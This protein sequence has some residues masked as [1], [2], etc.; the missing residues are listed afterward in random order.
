MKLKDRSRNLRSNRSLKCLFQ[1]PGLFFSIGYH[2]DPFCGHD[3]LYPHGICLRRNLVLTFK[4][5]GICLNGRFCQIYTVRPFG[6]MI[7]RLVK[8]NVTILTDP[9]KLDI[10][11]S[12]LGKYLIIFL[13][14]F[15]SEFSLI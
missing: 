8:T 4:K 1:D 15:L 3:T 10:L 14:G 7:C 6:K 13:T 5:S 9:K 11:L 2:Q 12:R